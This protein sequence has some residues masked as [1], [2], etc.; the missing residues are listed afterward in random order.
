MMCTPAGVKA[1]RP[2]SRLSM[3]TPPR[4]RGDPSEGLVDVYLGPRRHARSRRP[5]SCDQ[6]EAPGAQSIGLGWAGGEATPSTNPSERSVGLCGVR[7]IFQA[8]GQPVNLLCADTAST[9][10]RRGGQRTTG[11]ARPATVRPANELIRRSRAQT[12]P[13][14]KP[15]ITVADTVTCPGTRTFG[16]APPA[17]DAA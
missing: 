11:G 16:D 2:R 8:A 7:Q 13:M 6:T 12:W 3:A 10:K 14:V 4:A 15:T 17:A 5:P 9:W 1:R